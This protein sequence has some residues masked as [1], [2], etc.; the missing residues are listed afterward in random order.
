M[1]R[2][3]D[4]VCQA[5]NID[6]ESVRYRIWGFSLDMFWCRFN[7]GSCGFHCKD[8]MANKLVSVSMICVEGK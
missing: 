3:M 5:F 2:V 8:F 1:Q 6:V 4:E 7:V